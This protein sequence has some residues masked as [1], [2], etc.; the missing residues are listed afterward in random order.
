M[1]TTTCPACQTGT[2]YRVGDA[3]RCGSCVYGWPWE[4]RGTRIY[5]ASSWRNAHQP[6]V[7]RALRKAGHAPYDFREPVPGESGFAWRD[8][9]PAEYQGDFAPDNVPAAVYLAAMDHPVAR[10]GFKRDMHALRECEV[11]VL[12][13]PCG[14]SAHLEAGWAAGA[15]RKVVVLLDDPCTPELMYGMAAHIV[16]SVPELLRAL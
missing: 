5:V 16:T 12:V 2:L 8:V 3:E 6:D 15:G 11:C 4:K 1:S 13:L 9:A 10:H 14:R 7:V